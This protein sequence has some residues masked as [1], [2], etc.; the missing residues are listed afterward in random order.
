MPLRRN[1]A[2]KE[3]QPKEEPF[4]F[5]QVP[6]Y[7]KPRPVAK[8]ATEVVVVGWLWCIG[9]GQA[10]WLAG[11]AVVHGRWAGGRKSGGRVGRLSQEKNSAIDMI[12]CGCMHYFSSARAFSR[13]S[14][15]P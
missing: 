9:F 4:S 1:R 6:E 12:L 3:V 5:A 13:S 8:H 11:Q 2:R 7:T 15:A 10:A 14:L